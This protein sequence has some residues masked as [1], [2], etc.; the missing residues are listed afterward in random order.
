VLRRDIGSTLRRKQ[1]A[2]GPEAGYAALHGSAVGRLCHK[3][4]E[5]WDYEHGVAAQ[6]DE[7]I[8][9]AWKSMSIDDAGID[10]TEII[11][12]A[13]DIL[14]GFI[15]CEIAKE[16]GQS[17]ILGRELPFTYARDGQI[18]RGTIDLLCRRDG[19]LFVMDYKTDKD[20]L[21]DL[22]KKGKIYGPQMQRYAEAV[23][24]ALGIKAVRYSLIFLRLATALDGPE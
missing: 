23:A 21:E 6:L 19:K 4:L 15:N 20:A 12:E 9:S 5:R 10:D 11:G 2:S 7:A 13:R 8:A 3:V 24:N 18:V 16:L 17:E 22:P 1:T 14:D